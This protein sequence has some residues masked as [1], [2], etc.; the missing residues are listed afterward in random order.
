MTMKTTRDTLPHVYNANI[1]QVI[2]L[3]LF[4]STATVFEV[5]AMLRQDKRTEWLRSKVPDIF[6]LELT[7]PNVFMLIKY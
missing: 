7:S 5:Q 3:N 2:N 4:H 6:V 1:P